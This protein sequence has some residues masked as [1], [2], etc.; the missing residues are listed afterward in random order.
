MVCVV[1]GLGLFFSGSNEAECL[2]ALAN[3]SI[4]VCASLPIILVTLFPCVRCCTHLTH[5]LRLYINCCEANQLQEG[6]P[7]RWWQVLNGR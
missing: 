7:A 2:H 3:P 6:A 1:T 5:T 4:V